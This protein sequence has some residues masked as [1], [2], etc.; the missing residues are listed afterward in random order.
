MSR[1]KLE[2]KRAA[3][4]KDDSGVGSRSAADV[5]TEIKGAANDGSEFNQDADTN[6]ATGTLLKKT[7]TMI[8]RATKEAEK[9]KSDEDKKE[10]GKL[11]EKSEEEDNILKSADWSTYL[12]VLNQ[13]GGMVFWIPFISFVVF[14]VFVWEQSNGFWTRFADKSPED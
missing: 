9:K 13:S 7:T 1:N 3:P 4:K 12:K 10:E 14:N 11:I 6:T 5:M 2:F 8:D